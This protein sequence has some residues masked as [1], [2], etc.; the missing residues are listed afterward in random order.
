MN[1]NARTTLRRLLAMLLCVATLAGFAIPAFA[2]TGDTTTGEGTSQGRVVTEKTATLTADG[3]YT[4]NLGAFATGETTKT[5]VETQTP[6]DVVLVL[7]ASSSML[8]YPNRKLTEYSAVTIKYKSTTGGTYTT[9]EADAYP[10]KTKYNTNLWDQFNGTANRK[11]FYINSEE[12]KSENAVKGSIV[13]PVKPGDKIYCTSF[14]VVGKHDGIR[15][16]YYKADGTRHSTLKPDDVY[17]EFKANAEYTD[18]PYIVV[19]AGVAAMNIPIWS[20]DEN[21]VIRNLNLPGSTLYSPES[22]E[23][24]QNTRVAILQRAVDSF[25][26]TLRTNASNSQQTHK[27]AIV[28][29]GGGEEGE[30]ANGKQGFYNKHAAVNGFNNYLFTNTGLFVNGKFENYLTSSA[31]KDNSYPSYHPVFAGEL[32]TRNTYYFLTTR[33]NLSNANDHRD[34]EPQEV[35]YSGGTWG[36][37][38]NGT[39]VTVTPYATP[40]DSHNSVQFLEQRS[41]K[42]DQLTSAEYQAAL[43]N[44]TSSSVDAAVK[45]IVARGG[46]CTEYGLTI[47]ANVLLNNPIEARGPEGAEAEPQRV[48]ILFTDGE[49][50]NTDDGKYTA[51]F[52]Q[53]NIIR[54]TGN[55][56][57]GAKLYTIS[58]T[59]SANKKWMDQISSNFAA[60]NSYQSGTDFSGGNYYVNVAGMDQLDKIF[61][62][63]A[64]ELVSSTT[65]VELDETAVMTDIV[66]DDFILPAGF[67]VKNISISSVEVTTEDEETFTEVA[68]TE[69]KYNA[70][71]TGTTVDGKTTYTFTNEKDSTD[72]LTVTYNT[73]SST[74]AG[75]VSVSGFDYADNYVAA[76]RYEVDE[77]NGRK[78]RVTITGVQAKAE[79]TVGKPIPTNDALSGITYVDKNGV[80]H[81]YKFEE[82]TTVIMS[83]TYVMDYA[84]QFEIYPC[85]WFDEIYGIGKEPSI[86]NYDAKT[87]RGTLTTKVDTA[88]G[89][90]N[91]TVVTTHNCDTA[92]SHPHVKFAPE[93]MQWDKP[94][95][96]F[97]FGEAGTEAQAVLRTGNNNNDQEYSWTKISVVPANNIYYEDDFETGKV[98]NA[99]GGVVCNRVG[100]V[101]NEG[102]WKDVVDGS[103]TDNTDEKPEHEENASYGGVHG[104]EDALANDQ[105]YSGSSA[106][107]GNVANKGDSATATFTFTGT[108]VDIYSRTNNGTG[109]VLATLSSNGSTSASKVLV[110]DTVSNSGD[111]YQ[112]PTLSFSGLDYGTHTVTIY[113]TRGT[114]AV[115]ESRFIY[116]LDGIRVYNPIDSDDA[117]VKDAYTEKDENGNVTDT[118]LNAVF[119]EVRDILIN[120]GDFGNTEDKKETTESTDPTE[121][122]DPSETT[123]PT[124]TTEPTSAI[125]LDGAVF[126]DKTADGTAVELKEYSETDFAK[127]GPE[128]EVYLKSGQGIAFR[129]AAKEGQ[130]FFIGLKAPNI[131]GDP[132]KQEGYAGATAADVSYGSNAKNIEIKHSTD[133]YYEVKPDDRGYIVVKNVGDGLLSVTKIR[134]TGESKEISELVLAAAEQQSYVEAAV[135]FSQRFVLKEEVTGD[136]EIFEEE[137]VLDKPNVIGGSNEVEMFEGEV[138]IEN[139][140]VLDAPANLP[141]A[142]TE[143]NVQLVQLMNALFKNLFKWFC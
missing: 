100:I 12:V 89:D 92:G 67:E 74:E 76:G 83:K 3:T 33:Q 131:A 133:M 85:E 16:T 78:L 10:T 5:K 99:D 68:G 93:T 23:D 140:T 7:D 62:D 108:G 59:E 75:K 82:P 114:A 143:T 46:T 136:V 66:G 115:G 6:L 43:A 109:T 53:A 124:E 47:A 123:D 96:M 15:V 55:G 79:A 117:I 30:N 60:G 52:K 65:D 142:E 125:K 84:K 61:T 50:T 129:V 134:T 120:L 69:I 25:V 34:G 22:P 95:S 24:L 17:K 54:G 132:E 45:R 63:I 70:A 94:A 14:G 57:A 87:G 32:N 58:V 20:A 98:E 41:V 2:D 26:T 111:Y 36:Y 71:A 126:I 21:P 18:V 110:V 31:A 116:Y 139:P 130:Q 77:R 119:T 13:I 73:S 40:Y 91:A 121:T 11:S 19:P 122:T 64:G 135:V 97:V 49:T 35:T 1:V 128:N 112:I 106:H 4:I 44:V 104:W 137:I 9:W 118:E 141:Q 138:K 42:A 90:F 103:T 37:T 56:Q 101:Y 102:G 113:V 105:G 107:E 29:Y 39:R 8:V 38:K 81:F 27:L 86:Y 88:Y 48:V 80:E 51:I 72:K 28:T 127:F